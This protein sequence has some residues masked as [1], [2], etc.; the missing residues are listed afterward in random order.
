MTSP[1]RS[2]SVRMQADVGGYVRGLRDARGATTDLAREVERTGAIADQ[3][4]SELAKSAG[5]QQMAYQQQ[6]AGAERLGRG[7]LVVG[8]GIAAGIGLATRAAINW[9]SAW[10]GVAKTVDGSEAQLAALE[11]GLRELATTLPATHGEIAAVAEAAGQLGVATEDI[12][13]FTRTM[14]DLGESTNL[15]ADEAATSIAQLMNV[16]GTAPE[17][18]GRLGSALVELG[19]NG[20]STER[21]IIM[22]A[23]RI[24]GAGAVVGATEADVLALANALAS[25]GIEVEAGGSAISKVLV[26]IASAAAEGGDA[27]EGFAQVAGVSADEFARHFATDPV[28]A[29]NT[30]I[31]GLGRMN[32][33][34][35]D[36][37]GTLDQL[38]LSEI[39]TRDALLRLSSSGDL[40]TQ[41]L[42]DGARA[43]DE[44]IA[45]TNEAERRYA[46]AAAR[47]Q[48]AQNQLND[49]AIE[50]GGTFLPVVAA[51]ASGLGDFVGF[52]GGLPEPLQ[53][54]VAVT[55]AVTAGVLLLGG[56][57]LVAA[58]RI[59]AFKL[60]MDQLNTSGLMTATAVGRVNSSLR[61][62]VVW[63][64]RA[65][66]A[67]AALQIAGQIAGE[68]FGS[69]FAPQVD[70]LADSLARFGQTGRISGEAAR[71]LGDDFEHL[72]EAL[73]VLGPEGIG[74]NIGNAIKS[75]VEWTGLTDDMQGSLKRSR[76]QIE[77][78]D[79]AL[80]MLVEGGQ[81]NEAAD[82]FFRISQMAQEQGVSV[83]R[84][85]VLFDTYGAALDAA[86]EQSGE[87]GG[88][89]TE[90]GGAAAGAAEDVEALKEAFDLLFGAQMD[91]HRATIEY[92]QGLADLTEALGEGSTSLSVNT[93]AGRDNRSAILDQVD[94]IGDLRQANLDNG[95]AID[96]ANAKYQSQLTALEE[97]LVGMGFTEDEVHTL[98][99]AYRGIPDTIDTAVEND[100]PERQEEVE[101]YLDALDRAP[102]NRRTHIETPG[103]LPATGGVHDYNRHLDDI[104]GRRS[105][106]F[107]TP[108]LGR[109]REQTR[110]YQNDLRAIPRNV[111]VN[112]HTRYTTSGRAPAGGISAYNR[113]GGVYANADGGIYTA[114]SG[115]LRRAAIFTPRSPARFAF[116]EPATGGEAFVPRL[117]DRGRSLSILSTAANWYDAAVVS[118]DLARAAAELLA[119]LRS[120]GNIF[121]D[122]SFRG[123]SSLVGRFNDQLA[124]MF[125]G[126]GQS[127]T[128]RNAE[129]FLGGVA[130]SGGARGSMANAQQLSQSQR[131]TTAGRPIINVQVIAQPSAGA[132]EQ[133][134][135]TIVRNIQYKV[136]VDGGGDV[137]ATLGTR[138]LNP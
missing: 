75:V 12:E 57:A 88:A 67:V 48:V 108:G 121:E 84:L 47:I 90:L 46:T 5:Q 127:F 22:M 71:L 131:A 128:R 39:R 59:V 9:E 26:N 55:A 85:K 137:Q 33:A 97:L 45:L 32:D 134:M 123:A 18:V 51:A 129:R 40:L 113:W 24:S 133:L 34:G 89:I 86:R 16:M 76:Q 74:P 50:M 27:I 19:N 65:V 100:A 68:I 1:V 25:A 37:F 112:V 104:P 35:E 77:A 94:A 93:Q 6:L 28:A 122:F 4:A 8:A 49:F 132:S 95:M 60:A 61:S 111:G 72:G 11:G 31:L 14:I 70:N 17:D 138:R 78:F 3:K 56:T 92:K 36:V 2:V 126:R 135:T 23:Q 80:A 79:Q 38:G 114:Q 102:S 29:L 124:K 118:G 106:R 41:S 130:G 87:T 10:A 21:Q 83:E 103:L 115:L 20:A 7:M 64:G 120:G 15:T 110:A 136:R 44:N 73:R 101:D 117:G 66:A 62:T 43:W 82:A 30:F 69:D 125:Y 42:Q 52:L 98:I 58:P 54:V 91:I 107:S 116:A 63:G 119:H 109:S 96:E 53:K 13:S 81:A 105:T 99:E